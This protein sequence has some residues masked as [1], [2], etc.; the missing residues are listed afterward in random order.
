M[1]ALEKVAWQQDLRLRAEES[2]RRRTAR[3]AARKA[4]AAR[5][6]YGL[7]D[8]QAARLARLRPDD[9]PFEPDLDCTE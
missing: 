1:T 8:R 7:A 6:S 3:A 4:A 9:S 2:L 5:R